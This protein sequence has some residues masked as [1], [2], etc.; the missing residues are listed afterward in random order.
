M[1][2]FTENTRTKNVGDNVTF[3]VSAFNLNG[4]EFSGCT[5]VT[6]SPS[7]SSL[8]YSDNGSGTVTG[9]FTPTKS[10]TYSLNFTVTDENSNTT[11]RR[12]LFFVGNTAS[13]TT[14]YYFRGINPTHGQ[15]YGTGQ[16]SK[17]L[18]L[19]APTSTEEW[20]CGGWIQ[21][22]PDEIPNYPLANLSAIDTY[23]WYKQSTGLAEHISGSKDTLLMTRLLMTISP[24]DNVSDYTWINENFTGLNWAMDYPQ[25]WYWLSLK[26]CWN[27]SLLD[28]FSFRSYSEPTLLRQ[29]HLFLHHH[30]NRQIHLQS[31]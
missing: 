7:E 11:K 21:N 6:I 23:T 15:P 3:S 29:L 18:L 19:T 4:T 16:D 22:S 28:Y 27:Q 9:S 5:T 17:T 31:R 24:V 1:L 12:M 2:T 13:T 14:K 26:L 8:S 30:S 20:N 25:N 10:G